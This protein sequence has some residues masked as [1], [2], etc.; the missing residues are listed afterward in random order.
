MTTAV[1]WP[2][3]AA[4][5]AKI[6]EVLAESGWLLPMPRSV[7]NE[8]EI[9]GALSSRE[10]ALSMCSLIAVG[11]LLGSCDA[12]A[13]KMASCSR[14]VSAAWSSSFRAR[15]TQT[16]ISARTLCRMSR[17]RSLSALAA[18]SWWKCMSAVTNASKSTCV[19]PSSP[20]GP[21][22]RRVRRR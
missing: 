21:R 13:V 17:S 20:C 22:A 7:H 2:I 15:S 18:M 11:G 5:A 1:S 9:A 6:R 14:Q 4:F 3:R 10:P 8:A 19:R 16:R 12:S